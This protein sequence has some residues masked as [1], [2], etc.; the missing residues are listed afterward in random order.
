MRAVYS[1]LTIT[2]LVGTFVVLVA[3][4]APIASA[5][6]QVT[7]FKG[8]LA[9]ATKVR[10]FTL[11]GLKSS[12]A[13]AAS[14]AKT[15]KPHVVTMKP[16]PS[17]VKAAVAANVS[18]PTAA[19]SK[20]ANGSLLANFDGVNAVQN[21][22]ATGGFDLEP[23]D[24]SIAVGPKYV[25]NFVNLTGAIYDKQGNVVAGPF[26]LGGT[27]VVG[28]FFNTDILD[29]IVSDPRAYYDA[30]SHTYFAMVWEDDFDSSGNPAA[31]YVDLALNSGNP[32]TGAWTEYKIEVDDAGAA[33]CPCLPDFTILGVDQYNVYLLPNEFQNFGPGFNGSQIYVLAKSQLLAGV[34]SPNVVHFSNLSVGGSIV[35]HLQPANEYTSASAEYFL[36]SLDPNSTFD[37]RLGVWA[38]TNRNKVA[39]G[40]IPTL[41]A[42][43]ISSEAYGFPPNAQTPPGF[44]SGFDDVTTGVVT[45]DFDALQETQYVNGKLYAALDTTITIPGDTAARSGI[46][47]FVVTPKLSGNAISANSK[48][49]SQGYL[50]AQGLYLLY[51]HI[52]ASTDGTTAIVFSYG[53]PGTY[54]SAAYTVAKPGKSYGPIQTAASGVTSDNGFTGTPEFGGV[55]RWGDYSAGQLD[56][57]SSNIWFSTQYIGG[58]GDI[59]ANWFDRVFEVKA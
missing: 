35:Y 48:V 52:E 25:A 32:V 58:A 24:E 28:G 59:Y 36:N 49:S 44:D 15:V 23:P 8:T 37:N 12:T 56:P 27:G 51:P 9:H 1:L 45:T 42:T 18:R 54:L 50:A 5:A 22:T 14:T 57:S 41:S 30:A 40:V 10:S 4:R 53:G 21:S 29:N 39:Q 33:G 43:V 13:A 47:W 19:S 16:R 2:A 3:N 17:S 55:G 38:L 34:A 46:A 31:A 6:A 26:P 20:V 7:S 11:S